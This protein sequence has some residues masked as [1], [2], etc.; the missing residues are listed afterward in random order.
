VKK[1]FKRI[2]IILAV[3]AVLAAGAFTKA[4]ANNKN[5]DGFGFFGFVPGSLVLSRS[6]YVG[7]AS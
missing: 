5:D 2:A 6:V 3:V 7:N 4:V 1:S